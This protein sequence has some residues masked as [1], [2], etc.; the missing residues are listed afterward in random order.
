[1]DKFKNFL[2]GLSVT[3]RGEFAARCGTTWP[4]LRNVAY[5]YRKAGE[6]LCVRIE[7]ETGGAID[8]KDLRSDW[9]EIWPELIEVTHV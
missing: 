7:Q 8:R 1:M 4:F 2:M 9:R 6:K 5:E 3:E